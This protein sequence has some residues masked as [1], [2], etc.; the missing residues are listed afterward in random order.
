M[1]HLLH[2]DV[3]AAIGS[4]ALL[5]VLLPAA[6]VAWMMWLKP[7]WRRPIPVALTTTVTVATLFATVAFTVVRN[8]SWG[9]ALAP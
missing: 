5:L 9:A 4:N 7:S 2:G 1:H 3:P 8:T 6:I